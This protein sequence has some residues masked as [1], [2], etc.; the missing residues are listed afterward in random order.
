[1]PFKYLDQ[2]YGTKE[3]RD[4]SLRAQQNAL[5]HSEQSIETLVIHQHPQRHT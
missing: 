5:A 2:E 3:A 4:D 1:M